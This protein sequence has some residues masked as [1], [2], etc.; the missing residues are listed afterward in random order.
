MTVLVFGKTGQVGQA[1]AR[2][3]DVIALSRDQ[4]DLRDPGKCQQ[5]IRRLAPSAVINAAAYTNVDR[6]ESQRD[7]AFQVNSEA[8]NKMAKTCQQLGIPFIHLSS[9][10][11]FGGH[12]DRPWRAQDPTA[13]CNIYGQSKRQGEIGVQEAGGVFAILRTSWV[14][15]E[16][17]KNFVNTMLRLSNTQSALQIVSDQIG[18][19]T[20]A[21]ALAEACLTI[22]GRLKKRP[23]K[24][25]IYHLSGEPDVSW[26]E[27]AAHIFAM[28]GRDTEITPILTADFDTA[29]TRPLNSRL[30]CDET[31]NTF[32]IKRP[33]WR[34]YL[35][36]Q[37]AGRPY[38]TNIKSPRAAVRA[39][40]PNT[41]TPPLIG[42]YT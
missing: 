33:D 1:L 35:T 31:A 30:N 8:P 26:A 41:K 23:T 7:L 37:L 20:P 2:A 39:D 12:G 40:H 11:V 16:T 25:G 18:G 17:G 15:S 24:S 32:G 4:A 14:F 9:D 22:A 28:A 38:I 10:Y 19:P 13:P 27:F 6:A 21:A 5:I 29:A 3:P 34:A 36:A 42:G